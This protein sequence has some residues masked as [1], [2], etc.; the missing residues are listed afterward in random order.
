MQQL[1]LHVQPQSNMISIKANSDSDSE[2]DDPA[3]DE[4]LE[5]SKASNPPC[6]VVEVVLKSPAKGKLQSSR[7]DSG[8]TGSSA[9]P[10]PAKVSRKCKQPEVVEDEEPVLQGTQYPK[11]SD[12]NPTPEPEPEPEPEPVPRAKRPRMLPK[13]I[14]TPEPEPEHEP[15]PED[16][17]E[18]GL[19]GGP[20]IG[21]IATQAIDPPPKRRGRPPNPTH[22]H[23]GQRIKSVSRMIVRATR[24][25]TRSQA[26]K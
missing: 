2:P 25:T 6:Q 7:G 17:P 1:R 11:H 10:S 24:A 14:P 18:G 21:E 13:R 9:T 20:K 15:A 19:E 26:E 12:R 8:S 5:R 4:E 16:E 23:D 22:T 3:L